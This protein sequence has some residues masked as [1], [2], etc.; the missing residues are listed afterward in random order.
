MTVTNALASLAVRDLKASTTWYEALLGKG[1]HPMTEVVEWQLGGGGGLQLYEA[2]ERAGQ[3]SCTLIVSDID[4]LANKLRES[5]HAREV[6]P[7]RNDAV[8]TIMIDD[9][10]GNSIAFAM[11]KDD[12]LV[13]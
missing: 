5:G 6:E 1:S 4:A 2:P 8:D 3:G 11:P 10:D 13:R 12:Q 7:T 9:P